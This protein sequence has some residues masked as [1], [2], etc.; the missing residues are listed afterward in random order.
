MHKDVY[1]FAG[2]SLFGLDLSDAS[3]NDL[4]WLPP[5]RRGSIEQLISGRAPGVIG[6]AD[7]TFHSYPSVGHVE[8]REAINAGW[9]VYGLCSMG[10][11]R[12]SE[13]RHMGMRPW[14]KVAFMYCENPNFADDEV[15]LVHSSDAPYVPL[16]EPMVHLREFFKFVEEHKWLDDAQIKA[17]IDYLRERWYGERTLTRLHQ[18]LLDQLNVSQLPSEIFGAIENFSIFRIKQMDLRDFV[19]VR[20]WCFES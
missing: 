20:P 9:I 18:I 4:E 12:V 19:T 10:A 6:L 13:M 16:S 3:K 5:A 8:L 14:G 11:I 17:A 1:I 15:A 7:G 2:P